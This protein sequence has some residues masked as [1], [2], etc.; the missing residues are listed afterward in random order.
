MINFG[1]QLHLITKWG[2][3]GKLKTY[4]GFNAFVS[5]PIYT[6]FAFHFP[7]SSSQF[8]SCPVPPEA[9]LPYLFYHDHVLF[10][11]T[12]QDTTSTLSCCPQ[13][14]L[15]H[16]RPPLGLEMSGESSCARE[17]TGSVEKSCSESKSSYRSGASLL[18]PYLSGTLAS[19]RTLPELSS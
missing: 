4:H 8:P 1:L 16:H 3:R 17:C 7:A 11:L 9:L 18:S 15:A 14:T 5:S 12:L 13:S 2:R 6:I 19:C 10:S